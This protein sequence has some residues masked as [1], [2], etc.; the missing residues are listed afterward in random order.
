MEAYAPPC[1]NKVLAQL[2]TLVKNSEAFGSP[3]QQLMSQILKVV[4]VWQQRKVYAEETLDE[5]R[6]K[7]SSIQQEALQKLI[8]RTTQAATVNQ[9]DAVV[10]LKTDGSLGQAGQE[11]TVDECVI[12]FNQ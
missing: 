6:E 7:L 12:G 3:E 10:A 11:V 5:L 1:I 2:F 9:S 4:A 8:K